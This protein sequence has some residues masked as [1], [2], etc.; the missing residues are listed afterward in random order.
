MNQ[1]G[2]T[3]DLLRMNEL[4]VCRGNFLG[5]KTKK[6]HISIQRIFRKL[7]GVYFL[8]FNACFFFGK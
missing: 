1:A 6:V 3:E 5:K 7:F 8:S 2:V 4:Y